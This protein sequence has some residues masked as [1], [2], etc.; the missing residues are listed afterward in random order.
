MST[1]LLPP[2]P[3]P[4]AERLLAR[5]RVAWRRSVLLRV[6]V[7][8]PTLFATVAVLLV[9]V[10]L[11]MPLRAATRELLRWLPLALAAGALGWAGWRVARPPTTARLALLAEERVPFLGN[12][13]ATALEM[14]GAPAGPVRRAFLEDA[15]RHL[16]AADLRGVAPARVRVPAIVL[17]T[18]LALA[19]LF[20]LLLPSAAAE[21]WERWTRPRDAYETRWR[22]VRAQAM[23][24]S[25]PA[26]IPPFDELRWRIEPPAYANLPATTSRGDDLLGALPGSRIRLWS[27]FP[28]Q[29]SGVAASRIS[30]G[31]LPVRRR[32][33]E[34]IVEWTQTPAERGVSLEAR[35]N[36]EVVAR[37][38]LPVTVLPDNAPDVALTQPE[39][40]LVLASGT[41]RVAVRATAA[42]DY[43]VGDF[44][45][46]WSRTRGSGE[47]FEYVD[48][49]WTFARVSRA[50]KTAAGLLD[51]DLAALQ[52]QPGD[53]IHIRA[54]ARDRNTVTGPG[55]SVSRTRVIRVARPEEMDE[56]NTDVGFPTELPENP[57]LSQRM[58]ILR[59][60][61]L[62]A[63]MRAISAGE[64]RE[65]SA[66]IGHE[67]SRLRE[68]VGEQVFTRATGGTQD[69]FADLSF[70]ETA[71]AGHSHEAETPAAVPP[72]SRE[73]QVLEEADEATGKGTE[74]EITH[75]HDADPIL[76]VNRTLS[77][78]YDLMW[79][80]E[81]ALNQSDPAGSLPHQ[82]AALELI[83][84]MRK[85]D[86]LLPRGN[87][88]VDPV[89]IAAARGEGK[90]DEAA[91]TGR[92]AGAT[93]PTLAPLLA[94][95]DR[96]AGD[97]GS[98]PARVASLELSAL[99]GRLLAA[100]NVDRQGAAL[101]S[102]AAGE[103]AAG[104]ADAARALL[105]RARGRLAPEGGARTRVVPATADPAAAEYFRRLG[106]TP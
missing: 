19:G 72:P 50:G 16:A 15:E 66:D 89:D 102:Q 74:D 27:R 68:R 5:V 49:Q 43:G 1:R 9:A 31:A 97:L 28:E 20:A 91:P 92:A 2:I 24:R 18:S 13:L 86:R 21:A 99:A 104:R 93:L 36:G 54:V 77:R 58:L 26:P 101:V 25:A 100:P 7:L 23:P 37:R 75:K 6:L 32:G 40:D 94:E 67:Q 90:L 3:L 52:L 62:R 11:A 56:V 82:Y 59:T 73:A 10:D 14:E 35:A 61:R 76:E 98:K 103:A 30:G 42:D 46:T 4:S 95:L 41:G 48:G 79:A 44:I 80:S 38:V 71:G 85:T 83:Q 39:T 53:V 29:W 33:G 65:Q 60:E 63:R 64:L 47:S 69:P 22:E 17:G 51:L 84:E 78:I 8:A 55:E 34:W 70:T 87:V 12:R 96:A 105:R 88:R 81:R 106:R 57:L 45:L